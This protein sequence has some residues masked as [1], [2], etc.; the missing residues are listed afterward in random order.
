MQGEIT[1]WLKPSWLR[2]W[3]LCD[4]IWYNVYPRRRTS[5]LNVYNKSN[6]NIYIKFWTQQSQQILRTPLGNCLAST[7]R[8]LNGSLYFVINV[9]T[10]RSVEKTTAMKSNGSLFWKS[11]SVLHADNWAI[12]G[13]Y[14]KNIACLFKFCLA[15]VIYEAHCCIVKIFGNNILINRRNAVWRP[16]YQ[17]SLAL[18]GGWVKNN[19]QLMD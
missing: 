4:C 1:L 18:V 14:L 12:D 2:H 9:S 8:Q 5:L 11:G 3:I 6:N 15:R 7:E 16:V 13:V 10:R 17:R 19:R